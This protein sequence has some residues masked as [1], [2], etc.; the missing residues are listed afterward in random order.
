MKTER[1]ASIRAFAR[2]EHRLALLESR[3]GADRI[4]ICHGDVADDK[5]LDE[6]MDGVNIV[7]HAA[8]MKRVQGA[9]D[10]AEMQRINAGGSINVMRTAIAHR[11]ERVMGISSDKASGAE[12]LYGATKLSME[13][14]FLSPH[15]LSRTA[16]GICRYGNIAGSAGSV[17]PLWREQAK[18]GRLTIT[19]PRCTRFW[20]QL[21]EAVRWIKRRIELLE[22]RRLYVPV[23]PSIRIVDLAE[24]IAPGVALDVVG[25]RTHEKLHEQMISFDESRSARRMSDQE[26]L[27]HYILGGAPTGQPEFSYSSDRND[28]WLTVEQ[29]RGLLPATESIAS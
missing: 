15:G 12:T 2:S 21:P 24:A 25:M 14:H 9:F 5:R 27:D 4:R 23:L 19:D 8:A 6:V 26:T 10:A 11:V 16:F 29:I 3:F 20:F 28:S 18:T 17:V 22:P 13:Q 1:P 7:V